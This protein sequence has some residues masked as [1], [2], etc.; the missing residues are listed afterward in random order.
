M[1]LIH[2]S[3]LHLGK[4]LNEFSLIEDQKYILDQILEQISLINPDGVIIAGDIYDKNTPSIEAVNLLDEFLYSLCQKSL[5]IYLIGGNH[6][7]QERL[8]F[9]GR[10]FSN[11]KIY[12]S[13][14]Y[15]GNIQKIALKDD[16]GEY[17][18]HLLPFIKPSHVKRY[19]P[20]EEI[21]SYTDAIKV[22]ISNNDIDFTKRNILVTH[23]FVTGAT[24]CE[25]EEI[26]VGG[27]DNVDSQVFQNFDYVALGHI[28]GPQNVKENIRYCG[29]PLKYSFSESKHVKSIT[30][31][32]IKEK[33]DLSITEIPLSP[34]HDLKEIRGEYSDISLKSFAE[35]YKNDYLHITLTDEESILN[36]V[37]ILRTI[38]PNLMKLDYDNTR[39]RNSATLKIEEDLKTK[40]PLEI[41]SDF[42]LMQNGSKISSE[43]QEIL[44]DLIDKIWEDD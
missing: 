24:T 37:N 11:S 21:S 4:R 19:F 29:T 8:S 44:Q 25:S 32:E 31:V 42:Y 18:I 9:G 26:S 17:Y 6:D 5:P 2:L 40:S 20:Q 33:G 12:I 13:S 23:Q 30:L 15:S 41:F 43:Q 36:G 39:T 1:K 34:L 22:A 14:V 38:Y 35:K 7:S 28:H 10:I 16:Y 27:T 3:D